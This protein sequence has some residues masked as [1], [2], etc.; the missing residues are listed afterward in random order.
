M[1]VYEVFNLLAHLYYWY[2]LQTL[3]KKQVAVFNGSFVHKNFLSVS[4]ERQHFFSS[5]KNACYFE[6]MV[7]ISL[8]CVALIRTHGFKTSQWH[9]K[10]GMSR[11]KSL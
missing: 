8:L 4:F 2:T 6:E 5:S 11:Q 1:I 10:V 7:Q 3:A 9:C